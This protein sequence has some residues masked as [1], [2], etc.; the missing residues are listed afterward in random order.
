MKLTF[1]S[2]EFKANPTA[3]KLFYR[4]NV[5]Q[6]ASPGM[7][8]KSQTL[9]ALG[10]VVQIKGTIHESIDR[11]YPALQKAV[12]NQEISNL[13][14]GPYFNFQ[15]TISKMEIQMNQ[16]PQVIDY[17]IEFVEV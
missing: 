13:S 12:M 14:F 3:V 15:A 9:G 5:R 11:Q 17:E 10:R 6:F 1:G 4:N 8:K 7:N 2:F 16:G